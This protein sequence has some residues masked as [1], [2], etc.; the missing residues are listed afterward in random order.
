MTKPTFYTVTK[1]EKEIMS[2][3]FSI[4]KYYSHLE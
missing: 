1:G 4:F 2:V 3:K